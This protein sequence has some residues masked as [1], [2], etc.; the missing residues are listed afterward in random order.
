MSKTYVFATYST[1]H[2]R[3]SFY[4]CENVFRVDSRTNR[5]INKVP[6][7][8]V[9]IIT[10]CNRFY[11]ALFYTIVALVVLTALKYA[12]TSSLADPNSL[13]LMS[14]VVVGAVLCVLHYL[15]F[16]PPSAWLNFGNG[17]HEP[18]TNYDNF[19]SGRLTLD[20]ALKLCVDTTPPLN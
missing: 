7:S 1:G 3:K 8:K 2:D 13:M 18:K 12:H 15:V 14:S 11:A 10:T 17:E 16:K 19:V 9:F 5:V 20:E 6:L 4:S